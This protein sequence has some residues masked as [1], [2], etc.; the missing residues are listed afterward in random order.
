[1]AVLLPSVFLLVPLP[2]ARET[3]RRPGAGQP[4]PSTA[5]AA[6]TL[7]PRAIRNQ[8]LSI[9]G[10]GREGLERS[11]G[12]ISALLRGFVADPT[13]PM[14]IKRQAIKA[15]GLFPNDR[16]FEFIASRFAGAPL[17]LSRLLVGSLRPFAASKARE[18]TGL[19]ENLLDSP[20]ASLRHAAVGLAAS[21]PESHRLTTLLRKRLVAETEG[22]VR[23]GL[24]RILSR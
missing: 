7:G 11:A 1:M 24:L 21:L 12:D 22:A 14:V 8:L 18:I 10:F 15:L 23:R 5:S 16:N 13:E 17:S 19:L 20:H 2:E 4:P 3:I 6:G 9:H